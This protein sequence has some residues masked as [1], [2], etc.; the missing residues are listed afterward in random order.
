MHA[1][2]RRAACLSV[3]L[4]LACSG[5]AFGAPPAND[6]PF[7]PPNPSFDL[8]ANTGT[9]DTA[10]TGEATVYANEPLS[11]GDPNEGRCTAGGTQSQHTGE[12][13][14]ITKTVW[15][16]FTGTG[17]PVNVSSYFSGFDTLV[18]VWTLENDDLLHFAKCNDDVAADDF[19]SELVMPT[20]A[21]K[22]YYVQA[23]GC[24]NCGTPDS[25]SLGIYVYPTPANDRRAG[26]RAIPLNTNVPQDTLGA[27]PDPTSD[28]AQT[29]GGQPYGKT[30][31]YRFTIPQAGTATF[32]A[33]GFA[34]AAAVYAGGS[35]TPLA[36]STSSGSGATSFARHLGPGTYVLQVGGRGAGLGAARGDLI[37][38][39]SFAAD[40]VPPKDGDGDGVVDGVDQC[41]TQNAAARD[42]NRDGCLDPDP[43]PDGDGVPIGADKCPTEN[44]R[45][46]D[47]NG[48]GCLDPLPRKRLSADAR[49]RATPTSSGLRVVWLRVTAPKGSKVTVRCGAGCK[50]AKKAGLRASAARTLS[51]KKL[52]GRAFKAGQKIRIYVTR[53]GRIGTY[54]QYTVQRGNFKRV[55]RCLNPGSMKPRKRCS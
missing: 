27:Q 25:G 24:E 38:K 26:A 16:S 17:A 50:Y 37:T 10:T 46:R 39:V 33:S 2:I 40:P 35:A 28:G 3:G 6:D 42:A 36:C 41:P 22:T 34:S 52:E 29:C 44:A 13:R 21:G 51:V 45:A 4:V 31:W 14:R 55:K 53:K 19:T 15:W 18:S 7:D 20:T 1:A 12:G 54:I 49:L 43:D 32:D 30:V 23:G 11:I 47:K 9:F 5:T 8:D 48:D